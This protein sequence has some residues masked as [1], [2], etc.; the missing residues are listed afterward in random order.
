M[1]NKKMLLT[2]T[3]LA[4]AIFLSACTNSDKKNPEKNNTD[5]KISLENKKKDKDKAKANKKDKSN[6]EKSENEKNKKDEKNISSSNTASNTAPSKSTNSNSS[7]KEK[8]KETIG[9]SNPSSTSKSSSSSSLSSNS[10][11]KETR[12]ETRKETRSESKKETTRSPKI[13]YDTVTKQ[14]NFRDYDVVDR[15]KGEGS[16]SRVYQ[17]GK[18]GYDIVTYKITYKD[19]VETNREAT[20]RESVAS[21]DE[22]I[23]RYVKVQSEK[24]EDKEVDDL[25]S[26]IYD[27]IVKPRWFVR[28]GSSDSDYKIHYFYDKQEAFEEYKRIPREKGVVSAWGT[29]EDEVIDDTTTIVGYDRKTVSVKVA[30]EVYEWKH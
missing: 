28:E 22:I 4:F 14:E 24:W 11:Q 10:S 19:G 15:Y 30:D 3:L 16:E 13:T 18:K 23:E 7:N 27:I 8:I 1:K 26:P 20:N 6:K 25:T 29:A 17:E 21:K 2:I 12:R 5:K 9:E